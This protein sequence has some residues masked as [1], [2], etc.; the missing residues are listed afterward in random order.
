M[1]D[2][3]AD[4]GQP[5]CDHSTCATALRLKGNVETYR[6]LVQLVMHEAAT[7]AGDA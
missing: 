1:Y 4:D 5:T 6:K 2:F 7:P 3:A